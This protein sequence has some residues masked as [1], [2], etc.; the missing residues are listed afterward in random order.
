MKKYIL[1]FLLISF[2]FNSNAQKVNWVSFEQAIEINKT[3]PKPFIID[4]YTDWC[5]WC[6]KMDKTTYSNKVIIDY[7]N[8]HFHAVKMDGEGKDDISFKG[9]T[10]KFKKQ[11][12]NGYHELTATLMNGKLSYP[13][14]IFF[15]KKEELLQNVPG[16]LSKEKLEKILVFFNDKV[17]ETSNWKDFEKSFKSNL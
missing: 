11:G 8:T 10:F 3:D 7:I 12:R 4:I 14:T 13:S 16:Y 5:G 6:K 1:L 9:N 2:A 15:N 17:Y